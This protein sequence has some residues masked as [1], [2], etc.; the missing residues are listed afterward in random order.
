MAPLKYLEGISQRRVRRFREG[1]SQYYLESGRRNLP[2]R[3]TNDPWK[4]LLAEVLLRKT[5]VA[6]AL[7]VYEKLQDA[8]PSDLRDHPL[9]ALEN[10]LE[11]LGIHRERARLLKL[12]GSLVA[13]AGT[14]SLSDRTFLQSLPGVGR[15]ASSM[16]LATAFGEPLP[17]LDRNMI[18]VLERVFS[19]HSAKRRPHTDRELWE[20]ASSLVPPE[21]PAAFNWGVL[22][23]S[24]SLCKP[25]RP[26][27]TDCPLQLDCDYAQRERGQS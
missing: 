1:A 23:L 4:I 24:A 20:A 8:S 7:P 27:C 6:Q 13:E 21:N 18:R 9:R 16:V 5:T 11:P 15:Y 2:W 17:G 19:I 10:L 26:R 12:I 14:E 3:I 22:D 25:R